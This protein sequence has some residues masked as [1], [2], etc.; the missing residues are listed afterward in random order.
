MGQPQ[1]QLGECW[2]GGWGVGV[3]EVVEWVDCSQLPLSPD[4]LLLLLSWQLHGE[5]GQSWAT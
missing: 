3:C 5:W 1:Q 2:G 4:P